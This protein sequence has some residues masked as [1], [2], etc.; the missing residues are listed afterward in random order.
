MG[1][2]SVTPA[3]ATKQP[4]VYPKGRAASVYCFDPDIYG[5][6]SWMQ[7]KSTLTQ[8][9]C[10]SGCRLVLHYTDQRQTLHRKACYE[11]W[12]SHRSLFQNNG[13]SNYQNDNVGPCNVVT[14]HL[15]CVITYGG[16]KGNVIHILCFFWV[17]CCYATKLCNDVLYDMT[18]KNTN[19]Y[20]CFLYESIFKYPYRHWLDAF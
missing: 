20:N 8:V 10:V 6:N 5:E 12:C 16:L 7:L 2:A 14:E 17:I 9:G 15:K 3:N 1:T 11:L 13:S 4:D 19:L 18:S